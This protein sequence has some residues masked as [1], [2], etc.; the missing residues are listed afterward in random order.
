LRHKLLSIFFI[1]HL[2]SFYVSAIDAIS[3]N[4]GDWSDPATW[5]CACVP[6]ASDNVEIFH[7]VTLTAD[8]NI[9][10]MALKMGTLDV[11]AS[12]YDINLTGMWVNMMGSFVERSST[13]TFDGSSAQFIVMAVGEETFN[14][15]VINNTSGDVQLGNSF[16]PMSNVKVTD[17]LTF[18]SGDIILN[19]NRLTVGADGSIQGTPGAS[20]YVQADSTGFM[21][22][23]YLTSIS[24]ES[25]SFPIGDAINYSPAT[26]NFTSGTFSSGAPYSEVRVKDEKHPSNSNLT[27]YLNRYWT[28]QTNDISSFTCDVAFNYIEAIDLV[29][30]EALLTSDRWSGSAWS[31]LAPVD[32]AADKIIGSALTDLAIDFTGKGASVLPIELINFDL[33]AKENG[34]EISWATA[35]EINNDHFSIERSTDAVNFESI[36]NLPGAGT[37]FEINSYDFFDNDPFEGISYYR[38][39]QTDIDGKLKYSSIKASTFQITQDVIFK[40]YPNP[41]QAGQP[42]NIEFSN[43][44]IQTTEVLISLYSLEGKMILQEIVSGESASINTTFDTQHLARGIYFI[45]ARVNNNLNQIK[46]VI[47]N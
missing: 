39:K 35:V 37:S 44:E 1:F 15:L 24:S 16:V 47:S 30:A 4:N 17:S 2:T 40:V 7:T 38:L 41:A 36:A 23:E 46:L 21:R 9:N 14:N 18:T 26:L 29:G 11:S 27:D 33:E 19:H 13:V 3:I 42:V 5:L 34:I 45:T 22:N 31:G 43:E 20:S 6:G 8:V 25:F 32:P 10:T 28:V 12:S